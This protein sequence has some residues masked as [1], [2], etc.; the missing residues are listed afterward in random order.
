MK[1][2]VPTRTIPAALLGLLL[3]LP[4]AAHDAH[5]H[6]G[7][8]AAA[9][10]PRAPERGIEL[11]L[12]DTPLKDQD[13]REWRLKSDL[14][15]KRVTVVNFVYTTCTTVCPVSSATIAQLQSR[16]GASLGDRVQLVSIT[17][18]P[19]RDTPARLKEYATKHGAGPS[20]RWLTGRK[21]DV[22]AALKAFGAYTVNFEDHPAMIIVGDAEGRRWT[23]LYGFPSV[24][25][26]VA[27]VDAA[28][29][30]GH[31]SH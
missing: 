5:A 7:T 3:S 16:L 12:A 15:G 31:R 8:Q 13:G 23:R 11:Q 24:D 20:W 14:L 2:L 10:A 6:H 25:E 27:Q 22:D 19:Q 4:A 30:R 29:G 1:T 18:D 17:V 9:S 28:L 21:A 26:L